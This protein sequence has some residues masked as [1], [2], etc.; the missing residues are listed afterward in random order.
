MAI[1]VPKSP[2][3]SASQLETLAEYGEERTAD[4][5]DVLYRS[6]CCQGRRSS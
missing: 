4:V 6:A 3:L 2:T 5:G 1:T